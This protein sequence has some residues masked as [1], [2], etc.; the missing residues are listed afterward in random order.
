MKKLLAL[1][2][3]LALVIALL[4]AYLYGQATSI[5]T[6]ISATTAQAVAA[7]LPPP[8]KVEISPVIL[9]QAMEEKFETTTFSMNLSADDVKVGRCDGNWW[10]NF[11]WRD[12]LKMKV[13]GT[14]DAGFGREILDP[15][16]ITVSG[17]I[18]TLDIGSPKINPKTYIDHANVKVYNPDDTPGWLAN[19]N[20]NLQAEGFAQAEQ[21]LRVA[22][23]QAGILRA[24]SLSGENHYGEQLRNALKAAGDVRTV[25]VVSHIPNC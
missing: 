16:R 19:A 15:S 12:C 20:K 4:G 14:V 7:T 18:I 1:L 3:L 2:A 23:C 11:W 6:T 22:A 21:K 17:N 8:P 13:P 5:T 25:K 24:A 10:Q 9:I